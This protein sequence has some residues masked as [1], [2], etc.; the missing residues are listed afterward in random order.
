[1]SHD[2]A[3]RCRKCSTQSDDVPRGLRDLTDLAQHGHLV[4]KMYEA[5]FE[6]QEWDNLTGYYAAQAI[7]F[8]GRHAACNALEVCSEYGDTPDH[9]P[10]RVR[11]PSYPDPCGTC[12][13]SGVVP[14]AE[15]RG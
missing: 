7:R 14:C 3:Y 13:G 5:G 6:P 8:L 10:V 4:R 15:C 1:M 12:S 2:W 9:P 11:I